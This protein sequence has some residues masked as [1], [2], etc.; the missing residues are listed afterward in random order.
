M[1]DMSDLDAA[2]EY[3]SQKFLAPGAWQQFGQRPIQAG[4]N[5]V[6]VLEGRQLYISLNVVTLRRQPE[7]PPTPS[8]MF[9]GTF[10]YAIDA[11]LATTH[12]HLEDWQTDLE[13]F[14]ELV[15]VRFLGNSSAFDSF[16]SELNRQPRKELAIALPSTAAS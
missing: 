16:P 10:D 13:M 6:Y 8:L 7:Q 11:D 14:K 2:H 12:I 4:L 3:L 15:N 5:F 9:A 1:R